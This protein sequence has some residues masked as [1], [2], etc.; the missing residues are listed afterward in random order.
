MK[1]RGYVDL[2]DSNGCIIDFKTGAKKPSEIAPDYKRQVTTYTQLM[3]GASGKVATHTLVRTK[4]PQLIKQ[5]YTVTPED[6]RHVQVL[7]P[8]VQ[9]GMRSGL[10]TPNRNSMFCSRKSCAFWQAC[11][12]EFGGEVAE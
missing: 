3:P 5:A 2:L 10:Y 12:E 4:T 9:E 1:V 8:L 6:I 11:Q 7:Y